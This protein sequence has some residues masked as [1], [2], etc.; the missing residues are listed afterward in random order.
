MISEIT[1]KIE[2]IYLNIYILLH[3]NNSW[4][5]NISMCVRGLCLSIAQPQT[6]SLCPSVLALTQLGEVQVYV[7]FSEFE[8]LRIR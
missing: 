3:H 5:L 6:Q 8:G 7:T 2:S 4:L 1:L